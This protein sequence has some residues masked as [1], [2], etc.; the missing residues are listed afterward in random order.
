LRVVVSE[1][2]ALATAESE[3]IATPRLRNVERATGL[4]K[5]WQHQSSR[6]MTFIP[7]I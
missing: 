4:D 7:P 3:D 1:K 5:L 6:A 2:E